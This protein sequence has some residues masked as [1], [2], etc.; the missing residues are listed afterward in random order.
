MGLI[1]SIIRTVLA[2]ITI[3]ACSILTIILKIKYMVINDKRKTFL[4][5]NPDYIDMYSDEGRSKI[6]EYKFNTNVY[7]EQWHVILC[8]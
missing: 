3:F 8:T 5:N 2:G 4:R 7:E 6:I 1:N